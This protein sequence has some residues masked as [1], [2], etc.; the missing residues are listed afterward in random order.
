MDSKTR[1]AS[2]P[3]V[4]AILALLAVLLVDHP[5]VSAVCFS[6]LVFD[7]PVCLFVGWEW[8]RN[9]EAPE[10]NLS[11]LIPSR[12]E[13][14]LMKNLRTRPGLTD[15]EFYSTFYGGSGI[16]KAS[17]SSIREILAEQIGMDHSALLPDDDMILIDPEIDWSIIIDE[18]E[19]EFCVRFT[20]SELESAP[21]TLDFF[22]QRV[23][24]KK[25][26]QNRA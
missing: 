19:R 13:R 22:V 18:V 3:F 25:Q 6:V 4:L 14:E 23:F 8:I 2:V 7:I 15:D 9:G 26:E 24:A 11:P 20:D 21:A 1:I 16:P 5:V 17:V 12:A 10:V